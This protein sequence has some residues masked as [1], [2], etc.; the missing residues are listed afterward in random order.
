MDEMAESGISMLEPIKGC[1]QRILKN[2]F[3]RNILKN[4]LR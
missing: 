4:Y 3:A 2:I 1:Y